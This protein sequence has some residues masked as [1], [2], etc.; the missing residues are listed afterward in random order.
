MA[1][2]I[3]NIY[4][5]GIP[6][7]DDTAN[8]QEALRI[9]HYGRPSGSDPNTQYNVNNEELSDLVEDSIAFYL[10]D[11]QEQ[12]TDINSA[13]DPL[14]YS[15]K[16]NLLSAGFEGPVTLE[17][18]PNFPEIISPN[19]L[20]LTSDDSTETGLAWRAPQ[21]TLSTIQNMA[22][23][24]FANSSVSGGGSLVGTT[25]TQTLTNKTLTDA[26]VTGGG[27]VVGTTA[28]QTLTNK[29]LTS[30]VVT[31]GG[32]VVGTTA[33]QT[34]TNKTLTSAAVSGGG[35]VVG[36]TAT[37]TLTNKTISL[38]PANNTITGILPVANGGT[39][40]GVI[41]QYAGL[42]APAG[43]LLCQGQSLSTTTFAN[44]FA[45]IGYNYGGSGAS[46][47]V[48]N[49]QNRVPVGV[50]SGTFGSLNATGGAETVALTT[51]NMAAHTH[52]GTT[53]AETQEHVHSGTTA[54]G[55]TLHTHSLTTSTDP[56]HAHV[57]YR[58]NSTTAGGGTASLVQSRT[59]SIAPSNVSTTAQDGSHNHT[60]TTGNASNNHTHTFETGGRSATH[61][62]TFTTDNGTGTATAHNNL[63]PYIVVNYIIKT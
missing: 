62:H 8:I 43:Y 14:A 3:G 2:P 55:N 37:Q 56:D 21:V 39:P 45:A 17:L 53:A 32:T 7:L 36:T 10:K 30:A 28:T 50:G 42:A 15:K 34:L 47:N 41:S 29:T 9:Y 33:T 52:S 19:G 57:Y 35:S 23:K 60:A 61:N 51:A 20:V 63:Q 48:P 11:L 1:E 25:A 6:S 24:S 27:S 26:A 44:L 46:F 58:G 59:A 5:T 13:F 31:D 18:S 49:L 22:N 12:I 40:A 38:E 54:G 4:S 16:G